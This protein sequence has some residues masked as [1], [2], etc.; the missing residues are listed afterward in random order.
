MPAR[1]LA[2][3]TAETPAAAF[4]EWDAGRLSYGDLDR[5][6]T[7]WADRLGAAGLSPGAVVALSAPPGPEAVAALFGIWRGGYVAA[8]L[9]EALAEPDVAHARRLLRP[10]C[11]IDGDGSVAT[12][13]PRAAENAGRPDISVF[14]LTS[15]SSGSPK[16][17]G[18]SRAAFTASAAATH[19][20]LDLKPTDCWGL[21][22]SLGHVG[23]LALLLRAVAVGCSVRCWPSFDADEVAA[24]VAAG[25]VTHLSLVPVML[26]RVLD[27]LGSLPPSPKLRCVLVG[28]AAA[29]RVLLDRAV[30]AG[31][32]VA[33]TWG[34]TETTSQVATAPPELARRIPGTVGRPLPGVEVAVASTKVLSVAPT[35]APSDAANGRGVLAVRGPTLASLVVRTPGAEPEPLPLDDDGWFRTADVGRV[36]GAGRI[37][38][39]G[40]ADETIV[41]GG[42]NV[43]PREVEQVIE[44]MS[45]VA[46]AVVFGTPDEE[47]GE[48]VTAVVEAD[49]N[50]VEADDVF[51]YCRARLATGRRPRKVRVVDHLPRTQTGKPLRSAAKEAFG[52]AKDSFGAAKDSF[53]AAKEE[54]GRP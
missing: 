41:T 35:T 9:H 52:A 51:S 26:R 23:G 12:F 5:A 22:L 53:G 54:F 3:A 1:E 39:E 37:W 6:A 48:V 43:A 4:L 31:L 28:G 19:K 14:L 42:L 20:L 29:S 30:L 17:V 47:W 45:G 46:E 18:L 24:A 21:C 50:V 25:R 8:P 34:M 16:A 2:R 40:R 10:A 33:P 36:D 13:A 32:P 27:S 49:R 11:W 15:G 44:S 7:L 38:V